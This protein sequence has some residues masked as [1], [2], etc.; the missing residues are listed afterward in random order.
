MACG[1]QC[2]GFCLHGVVT[3]D[4]LLGDAFDTDVEADHGKFFAEFNRQWQ[5]DVTQADDGNT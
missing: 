4:L 5:T 1:L 3:A 2:F